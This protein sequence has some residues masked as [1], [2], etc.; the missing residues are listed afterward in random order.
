VV[1]TTEDWQ[2]PDGGCLAAFL[3]AAAADVDGRT[4][5]EVKE[6]APR[7]G[8]VVIFRSKEVRL[9]R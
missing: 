2:P 7:A 5:A 8:R 6:V 9:R 4:A 1:Y 3:G